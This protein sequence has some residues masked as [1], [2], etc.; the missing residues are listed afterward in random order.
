MFLWVDILKVCWHFAVLFIF[1]LFLDIFGFS[2]RFKISVDPHW[3]CVIGRRSSFRFF[4]SLLLR[5]PGRDSNPRLT[6]RPAGSCAN[7]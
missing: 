4:S 1:C 2:V 3:D 5:V 6:L 7:H